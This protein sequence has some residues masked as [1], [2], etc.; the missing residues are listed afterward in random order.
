MPL[1]T[2][3]LG[4]EAAQILKKKALA[5]LFLLLQSDDPKN[6]NVV[7][8]CL[9][10]HLVLRW[11][12]RACKSFAGSSTEWDLRPKGTRFRE[13]VVSF[14]LDSLKDDA[15]AVRPILET[16]IDDPNWVTRVYAM[17]C[18]VQLFEADALEA[19]EPLST[20][21]TVLTGWF[22]DGPISIGEYVTGSLPS[23]SFLR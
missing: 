2:R 21:D 1:D 6:D 19:L 15:D 22:A 16:L 5:G 12:D 10:A 17:E 23:K 8:K 7:R 14:C 11:S 13:Y 9:G 4:M 20:D 18:L 3:N